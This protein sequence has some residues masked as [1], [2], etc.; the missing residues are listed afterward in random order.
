MPF[1]SLLFVCGFLPAFLLVYW[2]APARLKNAVA[3]GFSL[4]FYA[5]GAPT[6]LPVVLGL[7][8]VDTALAHGIAR[9]TGARRRKLLLASGVALHLCVLG[10][11]KYSHFFMEELQRVLGVLPGSLGLHWARV[12]LPIG[13][14]FITFEEISYLVDVYRGDAKPARGWPRYLLFLLLFPHAIAG[15]I[16]RWRDLE[17]QLRERPHPLDDVLAGCTRFSVGLAKKVLIANQVAQVADAVFALPGGQLTPALAWLGAVAYALQIYFD[18]SGYS[19]M[20]IGLGRLMGFRFG[21][22]FNQPY[23]AASI[24][25]FWRRWHI[26]LS[27]WMRD[28]LYVPLGGNR[29]G[30]RRAG[31][32]VLLVFVLSGLWHGASWTF[33][34]WGAYHG[35]LSLLERVPRV[36]SVK[37][38]LPRGVNVALTFVLVVVGW[39]FFRAGS[40]EAAGHMLAAMAGVGAGRPMPLLLHELTSYRAATTFA[41]ALG[42]VFAPLGWSM[43][44]PVAGSDARARAWPMAYALGPLLLVLAIASMAN[45]KFSPLIYFRF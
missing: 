32:N 43:A 40:L 6:F 28:Y 38:L 39:V 27:T 9:S 14:S 16:F 21:E 31:M 26:S 23:R 18:F 19:D 36:A 42:L 33:V 3:L 7:A 35:V 5:W 37:S 30:P 29:A 8:A 24:T 15:P 4:L 12:V 17:P 11:F 10:Y 34:V 2:A 45:S 20:A 44:P 25:E 41:L 13:I 1:S 22:N